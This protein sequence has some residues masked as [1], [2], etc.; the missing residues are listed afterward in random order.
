MSS[1][2][3]QLT[4]YQ[5]VVGIGGIVLL[6]CTIR[7]IASGF[8]I[9]PQ[10]SQHI[11][12]LTASVLVCQHCRLNRP[13]LYHAQQLSAH[14]LINPGTTEGD[15]GCI[16]IVQPATTAGIAQQRSVVTGIVNSQF[17]PTSPATQQTSE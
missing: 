10:G 16:A 1:A 11:I 15:T 14:R 2:S 13:G 4:R 12:V 8:Q 5:S 17:A 6:P 9:T 3:L 7:S